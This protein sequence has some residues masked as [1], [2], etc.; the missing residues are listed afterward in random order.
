MFKAVDTSLQCRT[1]SLAFLESI[2]FSIHA[3]RV[4]L[5]AMQSTEMAKE[6]SPLQENFPSCLLGLK[7]SI[8]LQFQAILSEGCDEPLFTHLLNAK[9]VRLGQLRLASA[10]ADD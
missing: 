3:I 8:T 5:F 10:G 4:W 2:S 7:S 6:E 9:L 1:T